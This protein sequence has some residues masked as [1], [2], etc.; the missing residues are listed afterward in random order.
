ML[1]VEEAHNL[2]LGSSD[3][4]LTSPLSETLSEDSDSIRIYNLSTLETKVVKDPEPDTRFNKTIRPALAPKVT[5]TKPKSSQLY[6]GPIVPKTLSPDTV[7]FFAPKKKTVYGQPKMSTQITVDI[8]PAGNDEIQRHVTH[9]A[10]ER[11]LQ[12]PRNSATNGGVAQSVIE[13][14]VQSALPSVRQLAKS[15][16]KTD[17]QPPAGPIVRPKVIH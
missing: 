4:S 15:F 12:S 3:R 2:S 13:E 17:N 9:V 16:F 14:D 10:T 1:P 7:K 6:T 11:T 8:Q 5:G